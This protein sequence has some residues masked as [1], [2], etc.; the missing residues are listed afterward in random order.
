MRTRAGIVG[1]VA[2]VAF[3][4]L[5]ALDA[6]E[7]RAEGGREAP[8]PPTGPIVVRPSCD[9]CDPCGPWWARK[10]FSGEFDPGGWLFRSSGT[11]GAQGD[12]AEVDQDFSDVWDFAVDHLDGILQFHAGVRYGRWGLD[13]W[14]SW[15]EFEVDGA[16]VDVETSMWQG[17]IN[18][19]YRVGATPLG[20]DPCDPCV[21]WLVY[22]AYLGARAFDGDVR[23]E[24][25][26]AVREADRSWVDP[27]VGGRI[28]LDFR[29]NWVLEVQ[30][31]IGGFGVSSDFTWMLRVGASW[32]PTRWFGL[33]FGWIW[34][35]T[36]FEEGSGADRFVWDLLQDGPYFALA[37]RF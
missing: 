36:D 7:A 31:D 30:G 12:T 9:P 23:I 25:P 8:P 21:P 18:L 6:E 2:A 22:D 11:V 32:F 19:A 37:F 20:C 14:S 28:A 15:M 4:G 24:G 3:A 34:L 29:R 5:L 16:L 26:L 27:V 10:R 1:F 17:Q 33:R 35:D 13:L